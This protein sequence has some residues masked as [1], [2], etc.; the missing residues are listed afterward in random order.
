MNPEI[1]KISEEDEKLSFTIK[2]LNV[3]FVNSLR[4]T[5]LSDIDIVVCYTE[6]HEKNQCK[7]KKNT[8]RFHNEIVKHR[9]SCIPIHMKELDVLPDNYILEVNVT[10]NTDDVL[11]V[12]TEDFRIKNKNTNNYL[13]REEVMKIYPPSKLTNYYIDFLRLRPKVGDTIKGET[14][15]LTCDYSISNN[16]KDSAFNIVSVCSYGNTVDLERA[17]IEW[18]KQEKKLNSEGLTESEIAFEKKNFYILDAQRY[19][20]DD[21]F[22]FIVETVGVYENKEIIVKG[23]EYLNKNIKS[24][25]ERLDSS[26]VQITNSDITV[27]N[28]FNVKLDDEDNT[29]GSIIQHIIYQ[30]H[31]LDDKTVK[32]VGFK[33]LHP[34]DTHSILKLSF[35]MEVDEN[36]IRQIIRTALT[37][38]SEIY[39]KIKKMFV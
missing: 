31:F 29:I 25:I 16:G 24:L 28:S 13:T 34:H 3:S 32:Y 2:G 14:I 26:E 30:K 17:N 27:Q 15:E 4:R 18:E 12:T 37:E 22:D 19:Y 21:S 38:C 5:I 10:N 6:K 11:Y 8:T 9:L 23:C 1:T 36:Y 39:D 35:V 7:I 33:K 20:L